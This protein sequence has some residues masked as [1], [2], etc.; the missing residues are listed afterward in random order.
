M[1]RNV[2]QSS[3]TLVHKPTDAKEKTKA[4]SKTSIRQPNVKVKVKKSSTKSESGWSHNE[5]ET[6]RQAYAS[7]NPLK[8]RFWEEVS[9]QLEGRSAEECYH[10]WFEATSA[11]SS[12][13]P[14]RKVNK[15]S[16]ESNKSEPSNRNRKQKLAGRHTAKFRQQIRERLNA[17]EANHRDDVCETTPFKAG[18]DLDGSDFDFDTDIRTPDHPEGNIATEANSVEIAARQRT[19]LESER[20]ALDTYIVNELKKRRKR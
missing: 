10:Q 20:K 7:V 18:G 3:E 17:E 9:L 16:Q 4:S 15:K 12:K 6:L 13:K 19:I 8:S 5:L 14:S 11:K 1:P 2:P